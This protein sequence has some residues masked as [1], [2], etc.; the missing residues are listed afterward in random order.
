MRK[1][2]LKDWKGKRTLIGYKVNTLYDL[3]KE[4]YF[5]QE[6]SK[7]IFIDYKKIDVVYVD[8]EFR[9]LCQKGKYIIPIYSKEAYGLSWD[10]YLKDI[11]K[12]K[13]TY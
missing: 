5:I 7:D 2:Y 3:A 13:V 1:H 4:G 6:S 8:L 11:K 9:F 12:I 10:E